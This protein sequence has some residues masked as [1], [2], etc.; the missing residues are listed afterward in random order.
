MASET[1]R[2][3]GLI[4]DV[5]NRKA[6]E[7]GVPGDRPRGAPDRLDAA[8]EWRHWLTGLTLALLLFETITGLAI[9]LLKFSVFN[10]YG[11]LWHTAVGVAM[12][13]P[14][15]WYMGRHWWLRFRTRFNHFQLLGYSAAALLIALFV[16]GFVL[17]WQAVFTP[18]ISYAW[19][20]VH[21]IAGVV[22]TL[23]V[24]AHTVML[25]VRRVNAP[26]QIAALRRGK[27]SFAVQCLIAT[28]VLFAVHLGSVALHDPAPVRNEFPD[29]YS[30]PY[31][32]ER[33]FAPSLVRTASNWAYD[34]TTL[35]GS[36][37]CG[38]SGC[39]ADIVEEWGPSAHRY[40]SSDVAFQAVQRIM[41]EDTGAEST[42]YC[43]GC[44][45][46]IA[47]FS[48]GK[49]VNVEGLTSVG[50]DEGVSCIVCHSIVETD[51]RGNAD[52]K[53]AQPVR[54]IGER[55]D[56]RFNKFISDFLIRVYPEHHKQSF[57][58]PLYKT[59]EYCGACHKQFIDEEVN[60]IGWVQLQNQ[61]DNWRQSR[62]YHEG[63]AAKTVTCRECHMPLVDSTDPAAGD[64]SDYNR[65]GDD[66]K[67]RSHRFLAANQVMPLMMNLP[68]AAKHVAL[69]EQWLRGEID[70]PEIADKWTRGPVIK[71][72]L[73]APESVKPGEQVDIQVV[74][75][76]N[77]AGHGF[78][79]GPLDIIRSW[80]ELTVIDEDGN[81]VHE[82]GKPDES[83]RMAEDAMV[84]KAE[85]FDKDGN[86]IDR[87][88]LWEMVGARFKRSL[89]PG[90]SDTETY[91]FTCPGFS[92]PPFEQ[93]S[94]RTDNVAFQAPSAPGTLRV[95]AVLNYQK[96]D[97]A[98][99]DR[100][101][102]KEAGVRTPITEISS[103]SLVIQVE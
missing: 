78:P 67:H 3:S 103:D 66:G 16:S 52:Y 91:S 2:S 74:V 43:A 94:N 55:K 92:A 30:W 50:A 22:F 42:R 54:Y 4:Q 96:A 49:N 77:K 87:H 90:L 89:F 81:V 14:I 99:L 53:L 51:V 59:A 84:F 27:R 13:V 23:A 95:S 33:P 8:A 29:D 63:D 34:S 58:R 44:H 98:F 83:G 10:Q 6:H 28:V 20:Q 32:E 79:T 88:N 93:K 9:Y 70:I 85:G 36:E 69:T 39:H 19:G 46:P 71:L 48:G 62:W 61:Y 97:A 101:F 38:S 35:D 47:L 12:I 41:L 68:G 64:T 102:G 17:T 82:S 1:Q 25:W 76:N 75:T 86:D 5:Q 72:D 45:D 31:G 80:I 21:L 37:S 65:S 24:G 7:N 56:D 11:V 15:G 57:A 40:A 18:R 26:E 73:H 60:L 100:L